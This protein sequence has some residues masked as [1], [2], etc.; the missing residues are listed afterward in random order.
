MKPTVHAP[1][2]T[3]VDAE[4]TMR[5]DPRR[6][7]LYLLGAVV[8]AGAGAVAAGFLDNP[9]RAIA[10]LYM[11]A[12][13]LAIILHPAMRSGWYLIGY[14]D[15]WSANARSHQTIIAAAQVPPPPPEAG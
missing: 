3:I 13:G 7:P 2:A 14:S 4:V 6:L 9:P 15:G 10:A 12:I 1:P 5:H 8:V 11:A